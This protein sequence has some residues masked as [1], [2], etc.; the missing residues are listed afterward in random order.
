MGYRPNVSFIP[1]RGRQPTDVQIIWGSLGSIQN[2]N[3]HRIQGEKIPEESKR[4]R[5]VQG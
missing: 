3:I 5:N 1:S 2:H 4:R